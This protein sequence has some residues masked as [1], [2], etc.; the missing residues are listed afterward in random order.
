ME[1]YRIAGKVIRY[2][3]QSYVI[4]GVFVKC[5]GYIL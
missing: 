3:I 5:M 4:D 2:R 1:P